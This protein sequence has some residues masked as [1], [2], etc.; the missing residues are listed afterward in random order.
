M[1][2][3]P[4]IKKVL[5]EDIKGLPSE[6][7]QGIQ[8][9]IGTIN[10]FMEVVYQN[11]NKNVT[12]EQNVAC[13]VKEIV[14]KTPSTYPTMENVEFE[15]ELKSKASGLMLVQ[16]LVRG[17]YVPV[18]TAVYVPWVENNGVIVIY[19]IVGLQADTTYTI[20]LLIF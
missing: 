16:A 9:I 12:F 11:F 14:Y 5:N 6:I 3:L 2:K 10:N 7:K 1:G 13:F 8:P 17:T 4:T 15:S 19:P 18:T 20:R